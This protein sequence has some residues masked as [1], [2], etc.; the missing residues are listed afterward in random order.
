M[1]RQTYEILKVEELDQTPSKSKLAG[2]L[3]GLHLR[4]E[5]F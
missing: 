3:Q 2:R 5:V 1:E 4:Q